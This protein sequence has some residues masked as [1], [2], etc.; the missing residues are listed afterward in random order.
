LLL[1][2]LLLHLVAAATATAPATA[3]STSRRGRF[4]SCHREAVTAAAAVAAAAACASAAVTAG[5]RTASGIAPPPPGASTAL[6]HI[7]LMHPSEDASPPRQQP[8]PPPSGTAGPFPTSPLPPS[9]SELHVKIPSNPTLLVLRGGA[10]AEAPGASVGGTGSACGGASFPPHDV[11]LFTANDF[12]LTRRLGTGKF[13]DVFEALQDDGDDDDGDGDRRR[14]SNGGATHRSPLAADSP[15]HQQQQ[16]RVVIKCLKP[17]SD[18]K[19]RREV[20]VLRRAKEGGAVTVVRLLGIVL[21]PTDT[22]E[23]DDDDKE[24]SRDNH[25]PGGIHPASGPHPMPSLVLEHAGQQSQWL[26]HPTTTTATAAAAAA[27]SSSSLPGPLSDCEI[28]YYVCHLLAALRDLHQLGIMHRDVKPRNVLIN[29]N[30]WNGMFRNHAEDFR[31]DPVSKP[32]VLIDLGLADFYTPR[33]AYNVRVASRHYKSP[34]LLLAYPYYTPALDL[35]GVGCV[36]AGLLLRRE[37]FF[38]GKDNPDQLV[39]IVGVLGTRDLQRYVDT[40]GM[41]HPAAT[42]GTAGEEEDDGSSSS[43]VWQNLPEERVLDWNAMRG[44]DCPIAPAQGIDLLD[45]L[46]VYD[47]EVRCTAQQAMDHP[48]FDPV[49]DR[50]DVEIRALRRADH[51]LGEV[52]RPPTTP[53]NRP[54]PESALSFLSTTPDR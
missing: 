29:R 14:S 32:L 39:K 45:C 34:E 10:E 13:S 7:M 31:Q 46:L 22:T 18:R 20:A 4:R 24:N 3:A 43:N 21:H 26:C 51:D 40:Y 33:I 30:N 23:D 53:T 15:H 9:T 27:A 28:R 50:V 38:R 42:P 49:R 2:L 36:L 11:P 25:P 19:V 1:L 48:F 12:W 54:V 47:H 5:W 37:P 17:V 6:N 52:R 35:W 8:P 41:A 16:R 44:P